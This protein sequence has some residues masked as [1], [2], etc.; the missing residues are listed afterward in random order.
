MHGLRSWNRRLRRAAGDFGL[1]WLIVA[2]VLMVGLIVCAAAVE[3]AWLLPDTRGLSAVDRVKVLTDFR[4][5]L[6]TM[7]GGLAVLMAGTVAAVNV[8]LTQRVQWRAMVTDRFSKAIEQLGRRGSDDLDVRIG[9]IYALEQIARDSSELHWPIMEVLSAYL[10]QHAPVTPPDSDAAATAKPDRI[11]ADHQAIATV[12][13]RRDAKQDPGGAQLDLRRTYLAGADL[14][15][16]NLKGANLREATLDHADLSKAC[17]QGAN[18]LKADLRAAHFV[19]AHLDGA[20]LNEARL[21]WASLANARMH[22][23]DMRGAHLGNAD[24]NGAR[25]EGANLSGVH[26]LTSDQIEMTMGVQHAQLPSHLPRPPHED[27]SPG[28]E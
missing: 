8:V 21:D 13:G 25:V 7:L 14:V 4:N 26:G 3:P 18:L 12:L 5:T 22:G 17:L 2:G 10:R 19:A 27:L 16:A 11:A 6:M 9:A 15:G 28:Q 24:L 1:K 20:H 23:A